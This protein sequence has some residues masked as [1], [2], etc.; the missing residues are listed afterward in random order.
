MLY[1]E[2]VNWIEVYISKLPRV[3]KLVNGMLWGVEST[4]DAHGWLK[5]FDELVPWQARFKVLEQQFQNT[6]D[7]A[8]IFY[9]KGVSGVTFGS[10]SSPSTNKPF[11]R[12]VRQI[13][14]WA[15]RSEAVRACSANWFQ[16]H[17]RWNESKPDVRPTMCAL[18]AFLAQ[19]SIFAIKLS[20]A[21]VER[22]HGKSGCS[23][24]VSNS[25]NVTD[26]KHST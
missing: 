7:G 25:W 1:R 9:C 23:D 12:S 2:F 3:T 4:I 6:F 18:A 15:W 17:R 14:S 10:A 21:V 19:D 22:S 8:A 16:F 20:S 26:A 11:G 13:L 5:M 24:F